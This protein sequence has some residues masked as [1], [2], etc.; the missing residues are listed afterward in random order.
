MSE[1]E[2]TEQESTE[3]NSERQEQVVG[4]KDDNDKADE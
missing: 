2:S 4:S 1:Q 3:S